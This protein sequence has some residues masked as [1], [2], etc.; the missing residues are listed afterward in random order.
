MENSQNCSTSD[1]PTRRFLRGHAIF[2]MTLRGEQ[3]FGGQWY[4]YRLTC[5]GCDRGC[6][7]VFTDTVSGN[8]RFRP[9]AY[10]DSVAAAHFSL[11]KK[12]HQGEQKKFDL[13]D[14]PNLHTSGVNKED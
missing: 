3:E 13:P 9:F 14:G 7:I 5:A 1:V 12:L 4:E 11:C 6:S 10:A 2:S 8:V